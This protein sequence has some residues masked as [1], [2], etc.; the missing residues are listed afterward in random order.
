M[1]RRELPK[2]GA[3]ADP[4]GEKQLV[5][6]QLVTLFWPTPLQLRLGRGELELVLEKSG[7][8]TTKG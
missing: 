2:V 3:E 6:N 4:A 8:R 7:P 5:L 1:L